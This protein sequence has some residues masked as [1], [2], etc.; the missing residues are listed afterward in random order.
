VT[1]PYMVGSVL[2]GA[3]DL[4][5]AFVKARIQMLG[6]SNFRDYTALGVV[7]DHKLLGGVVYHAYSGHDIQASY[8][9]ESPRW[10]SRDVLRVLFGYP[11]NQLGCV[12]MTGLIARKNK[13]AREMILR[14]GFT[15]EGVHRKAADGRQD[16]ISYGM[17]K[18]EC[19]WI[20]PRE[21]ASIGTDHGQENT[22]AASRA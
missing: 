16:A 7:K 13:H 17:L 21:R 18:S 1:A 3:D 4:V 20:K 5:A 15:L 9:F 11:F 22:N 2:F 10:A 19:K 12:R 14:L 6:D 8:A